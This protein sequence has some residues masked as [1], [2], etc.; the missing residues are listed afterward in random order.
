MTFK[1]TIAAYWNDRRG[2]FS[3]A[4]IVMSM[5]VFSALGMGVDVANQ[6]RSKADLQNSIDA[7][8]LLGAKLAFDGAKEAE[9][10]KVVR[11]AYKANCQIA[12]CNPS[13]LTITLSTSALEVMASETVR[14]AFMGLA[15]V[16][17]L[18]IEAKARVNLGGA[19]NEFFE[20]HLI[21]DNTGS[22]NIVDGVAA[23]NKMVPLFQPYEKYGSVEGCAFACHIG[24]DGAGQ[25]VLYN[26]KTGAE[27]AKENGIPMREDR[28]HSEMAKQA[29]RL[30]EARKNVEVGVHSFTWSMATH[31]KPTDKLS[32]VEAAIEAVKNIS[33]G[34]QVDIMAPMAAREIGKSGDGTSKGRPKKIIVLMTDGVQQRMPDHWPGIL[35]LEACNEMKAEGRELYVFNVKYPDPS[36]IGGDQRPGGSPQKVRDIYSQIEPRLQECASSPAHYFSADYGTSIDNALKAITDRILGDGAGGGSFYMSM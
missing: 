8:T 27:I 22:M 28:V 35:S 7:A 34:T 20:V 24:T 10:K 29:K 3:V 2:Q 1:S 13:S 18:G 11:D 23:I 25:D 32:S 15:G 14:T 9:V 31:L 19:S 12:K 17:T 6:F 16:S 36:I 26:G 21:L 30:L 4:L 33:E 5:T